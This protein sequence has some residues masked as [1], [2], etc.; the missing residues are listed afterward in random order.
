MRTWTIVLNC[1]CSK[2]ICRCLFNIWSI[3]ERI[4]GVNYFTTLKEM[5]YNFTFNC[6]FMFCLYFTITFM[7]K[8]SSEIHFKPTTQHFTTVIHRTN[9]ILRKHFYFNTHYSFIGNKEASSVLNNSF[10][11][12]SSI[13]TENRQNLVKT[14]YCLNNHRQ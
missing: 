4:S 6:I 2:K 12:W 9:T 1:Y 14:V 11:H 8:V 3:G 10:V 13:Y 5:S 7:V